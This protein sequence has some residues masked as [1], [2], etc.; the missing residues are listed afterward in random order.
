MRRPEG[1]NDLDA[2]VQQRRHAIDEELREPFELFG[3]QVVDSLAASTTRIVGLPP[4]P[5]LGARD[6]NG[7]GHDRVGVGGIMQAPPAVLASV[8]SRSARRSMV[9]ITQLVQDATAYRPV[10]GSWTSTASTKLS[11]TPFG[12]RH[13]QVTPERGA[14]RQGCRNGFAPCH[15]AGGNHRLGGAHPL[16][17]VA[18]GRARPR[19]AGRG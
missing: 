12:E 9:G 7:S 13:D 14:T 19:C 2:C 18:A 6:Q 3:G 15:L 4:G 11:G 5:A 8:A 10:V 16:G 17:K 1:G